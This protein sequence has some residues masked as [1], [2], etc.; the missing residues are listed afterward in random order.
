MTCE[1]TKQQW[2]DLNK[3]LECT[4]N[5]YFIQAPLEMLL[6]HLRN[7]NHFPPINTLI[8]ATKYYIFGCGVK[9]KT[10]SFNELSVNLKM[11]PQEQLLLSI[12]T[13][14]EVEF[15]KNWSDLSKLFKSDLSE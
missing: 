10:P 11:C 3:C 9:L 14:K 13:G 2:T 8:L 12:D 5:K 4:L 7:Y 1:I 15:R 6:Y